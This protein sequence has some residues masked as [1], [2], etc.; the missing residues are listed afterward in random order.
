[1]TNSVVIHQCPTPLRVLALTRCNP[2][3]HQTWTLRVELLRSHLRE[4][5]NIYVDVGV[6]PSHADEKRA[7]LKSRG[8][9]DVV[10]LHRYATW[11]WELARLRN[12]GRHLVLDIDDPIGYSSS[13]FANF[14]LTRWLKF[15]STAR[16]CDAVLA[17]SD[18]L[19]ELATPYNRRTHLARLCAD[20]ASHSM[21]GSTRK[22]GEPLRLLWLGTR[23][24]FKYVEAVR[25]H[26]EAIGRLGRNI[27]LVIVGHNRLD[28]ANLPVT[29]IAWSRAAEIE[30]FARCHVGL[31][32][33]TEDRWT[34]AKATLKPLQYLANGM[35][36]VASPV[37]VNLRI[38]DQSC[39]GL[40]A[41]TPDEWAAAVACFDDDENLRQRM[42]RA[43][44]E[45]VRSHHSPEVLAGI[46]AEVFRNV[47]TE[48]CHSQIGTPTNS[49]SRSRAA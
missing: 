27:E 39:N 44:I 1:M 32:P 42:G 31:V 16:R 19:V 15:R 13:N 38:S 24:T 18:G 3:R 48:A 7:F 11:P 20:P 29:N 14:S 28:L 2:E 22:A 30:Q 21:Q 10:W 8:G 41:R 49:E 12:V 35:P 25:P 46:V 17:A 4:T 45:Y 47:T 23:S 33:L 6:L 26:L 37:G 34:R 5:Y 36:F 9:Y 40:L 43:G